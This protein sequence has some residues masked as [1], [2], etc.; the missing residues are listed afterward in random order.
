MKDK[1]VSLREYGSTL[2]IVAV[3][4]TVIM[5]SLFLCAS[6]AATRIFGLPLWTVLPIFAIVMLVWVTNGRRGSRKSK[7]EG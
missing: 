1:R 7:K 5:T 2:Y 4:V 6:V 3:V